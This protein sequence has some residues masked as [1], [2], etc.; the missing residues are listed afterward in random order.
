M[1]ALMTV[2]KKVD[3]IS[4]EKNDDDKAFVKGGIIKTSL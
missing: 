2:M 4:V 3:G 1:S